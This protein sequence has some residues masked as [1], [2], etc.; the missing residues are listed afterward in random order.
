MNLENHISELLFEHDCV[1]VPGFGGFV[2]N[3]SSANIHPAKHRFHPPFK[4]I[5]FNRNLKNNDG[6]LANQV[7]QEE[8]ISYPDSNRCI[9]EYVEKL[10]KELSTG[11]RFDL[12]N[13]GTFYLGEENTFLFEQDETINYLPDSFGLSTFYSPAIK[14]EPI[15]RRI[16]KKLKDKIIVPSKEKTDASTTLSVTSA[17]RKTSRYLVASAAVL[18]IALLLWIP[19]QTG[20]LKNMDYSSLNPFAAKEKPLYQLSEVAL[21]G[22]DITK[23]NAGNLLT[24]N[25]TTR[26]INILING[27]I[28]IVVSLRDDKTAV[29]KTKSIRHKSNG[30]FHIIGGAFAISENADKFV[31]KLKKLGYDAQIID[32]KLHM[33]SYGSFSTREEALQ[34]LEKI[35]TVQ[36]DVWLTKM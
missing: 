19:F 17:K 3:Y 32:K 11:K 7:A 5:S 21:P 30:H 24:I 10:N 29:A 6:L 28:P 35:R 22:N 20:L 4:K 8:K 18:V 31:V 33:V 1:I 9:S 25:D 34:A 16:E 23:E 14:R 15:E 2:C 36:N 13:I 26:Y 27:T 12:K